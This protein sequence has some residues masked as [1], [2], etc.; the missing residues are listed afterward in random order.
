MRKGRPQ[1]DSVSSYPP[2]DWWHPRATFSAHREMDG[3]V[4]LQAIEAAPR[5]R[6]TGM[7]WGLTETEAQ[8][9][10]NDLRKALRTK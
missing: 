8:A 10:I 4:W 2:D 5:D 7:A 6:R 1:N 3:K 9:L